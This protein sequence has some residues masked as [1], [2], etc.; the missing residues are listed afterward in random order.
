MSGS[1]AKDEI[2]IPEGFKIEEDGYGRD[3]SILTS[4][5]NYFATIDWKNRCFRAGGT[6]YGQSLTNKSYK[7]PGWR[8]MLVND[9]VK[10]LK[11]LQVTGP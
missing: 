1:K 8:Q 6:T 9:A 7:G 11:K 4:P 2:K 3:T 10:W 5:D